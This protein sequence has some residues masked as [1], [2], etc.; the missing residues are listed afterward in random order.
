VSSAFEGSRLSGNHEDICKETEE[1]FTGRGMSLACESTFMTGGF[2]DLDSTGSLLV[3]SPHLDDAVFS[4]EALLKFARDVHVLTI[5]GGDA[6]LD[7]PIAEWDLQCG[8]SAGMNVMEARRTEDARALAE[9]G[10]IPLWGEELQEGHRVE[11]ADQDR[12]TALITDTIDTISPSHVLFPLGLSHHDHLLVAAASGAAARARK[13]SSSFVYADRPY[14]QRK[15]GIVSKR[16]SELSASGAEFATEWLPRRARR[17]D[18]SAI[19]CY[20]SQLR[21]L[22]MSAFRMGLFRERYWRIS[23]RD[24]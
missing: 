8:F 19:R 22:K 12:L 13:R 24:E 4:C 6:P 15:L 1:G 5:F 14:A 23:W 18:R 17:G 2:T 16:R 11:P 9:L 21:G 20:A 7:A 3:I 10:A